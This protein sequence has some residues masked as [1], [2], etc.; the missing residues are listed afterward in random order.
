[1]GVL[2]VI[3]VLRTASSQLFCK[4]IL[5]NFAFIYHMVKLVFLRISNRVLR[6]ICVSQKFSSVSQKVQLH[7]FGKFIIWLILFVIYVP[8]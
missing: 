2:V 5:L 3:L 4:N 8:K 7:V 1:V 6:H